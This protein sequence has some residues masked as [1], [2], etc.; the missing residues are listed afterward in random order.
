MSVSTPTRM[1]AVAEHELH[2]LARVVRHGNGH[3]P[4]SPTANVSW[5]SNPYTRSMPVEA[6]ADDLQ[7]PERDPHGM[8]CSRRTPARRRRDRCARA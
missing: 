6:L 4:R 2:R 8:R 5:L 7:R 1:R 3:D